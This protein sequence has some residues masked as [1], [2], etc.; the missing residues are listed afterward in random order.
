M[1]D[2]ELAALLASFAE[3]TAEIERLKASAAGMR[4]QK[5]WA[6]CGAAT[7]CRH[8]RPLAETLPPHRP[9][10]AGGEMSDYITPAL[11]VAVIGILVAILLWLLLCVAWWAIRAAL[12]GE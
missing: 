1:N 6:A 5:C 12:E 10:R 11:V 8:T 9:R 3:G 4:E 7:D 2:D